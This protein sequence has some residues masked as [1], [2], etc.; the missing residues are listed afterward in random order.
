MRLQML[1]EQFMRMTYHI[2]TKVDI[3]SMAHSVEVR[4]PLLDH[5]IAEFA[6]SLPNDFLIH[7]G[8]GKRILRDLG[9]DVLPPEVIG[10]RKTG[11]SIPIR[12]L[13]AKELKGYLLETL[14][15]S[16]PV[17]DALVK[18]QNVPQIIEAH[19]AGRPFE[20]MLLLK[21]LALRL[22]IEKSQ[23]RLPN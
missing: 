16:H 5:R 13:F 1:S 21:L 22:W 4:S 2:L 9:A 19:C 20:T 12:D 17:Y 8:V 3:T 15:S 18:R 6:R 10:K 11:F 7:N 23:P 14:T